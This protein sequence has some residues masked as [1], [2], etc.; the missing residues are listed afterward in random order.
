VGMISKAV[1]R[2]MPIRA[3]QRH[4]THTKV[5]GTKSTSNTTMYLSESKRCERGSETMSSAS[6]ESATPAQP[7]S[8]SKRHNMLLQSTVRNETDAYDAEV[9]H[10]VYAI[11]LNMRDCHIIN[12]PLDD[13]MQDDIHPH[14]PYSPVLHPYSPQIAVRRALPTPTLLNN[15][16]RNPNQRSVHHALHIS[17]FKRTMRAVGSLVS[18]LKSGRASAN[19]D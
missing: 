19:Q 12:I 15:L 10:Q 9:L 6:I 11:A 4:S 2:K 14:P 18:K 13:S 16:P 17:T 5:L 8:S 7:H 1:D 3:E